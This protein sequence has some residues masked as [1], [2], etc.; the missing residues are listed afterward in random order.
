[1]GSLRRG[2]GMT[3]ILTISRRRDNLDCRNHSDHLPACVSAE[4]EDAASP[5]LWK[6]EAA[7]GVS[8]SSCCSRKLLRGSSKFPE[9]CWEALSRAACAAVGLECTTR[10]STPIRDENCP[11]SS[12]PAGPASLV[13]PV[14]F[15]T[16]P[17]SMMDGSS[18]LLRR[19]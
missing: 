6:Q 10:P 1:M 16:A 9:S 15:C 8:H 4:D 11:S 12:A 3:L 19:N 13:L 7:A 18:N 17:R 2:N 14:C 5:S